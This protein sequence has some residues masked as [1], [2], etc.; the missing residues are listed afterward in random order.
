MLYVKTLEKTPKG[1]RDF[2]NLPYRLYKNDPHWVPPIYEMLLRSLLGDGNPM[3]SDEHRFFLAYEDDRPV[4][5]VLAGVDTRLTKQLGEKRGYISLFETEANM[6][7]ARLVLEAATTY[8]RELGVECVVG[9]NASNF[10]DLNKGLLYEGEEGMPVLSNPYNPAFYNEYLS[11]YGFEKHRDYYAY[12]LNLSDFPAEECKR[13]GEMAQ[14]RFQ[15]R[16]ESVELRPQ[17]LDRIAGEIAQ[18]VDE[19]FSESGEAHKPTKDD[20]L[21]EMKNILG[22]TAPG[23]IVLAYAGERPIGVFVALPD[24]NKLLKPNQGRLFP[25][26]WAT[27]LFSRKSVRVARC[28]ILLVSPDYQNKAVSVAMALKAYENAKKF[29]IRAVEASAIDEMDMQSILNT[30]RLGAKRYRVYRQYSMKL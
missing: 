27:M 2:L 20:I 8:L 4:A 21:Q 7:C 29:G 11:A 6:E 23:L 22:Y 12:W 19:S 9:P 17:N 3:M 5:R 24:Y 13:L 14:K 26:G 25:F 15:F 16:V 1:L 10:H 30:E 18:I 28:S